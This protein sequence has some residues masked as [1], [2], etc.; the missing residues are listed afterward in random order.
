[1]CSVIQPQFSQDWWFFLLLSSDQDQNE[2]QKHRTTQRTHMI[3]GLSQQR[4]P[5][6]AVCVES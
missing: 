6:G 1:M 5:E 2:G 4:S 3:D